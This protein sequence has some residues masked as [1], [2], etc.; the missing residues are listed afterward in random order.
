MFNLYEMIAN[1]QNGAA[2]NAMAQQFGLTPQQ[3]QAAIEALLP[4]FTLGL[5]QATQTPQG[6]A[7]LFATMAQPQA[8]AAFE[9]P[10]FAAQMQQFGTDALAAMFGSKDV[11]RAVADQAAPFA[12]VGPEILKKMLPA[13]AALIMSGL[14]R[15]AAQTQ[16]GW[17]DMLDQVFKQGQAPTGQ[18][19]RPGGGDPMS[20]LLGSILGGMLGAG[21]AGGAAPRPAPERGSSPGLDQLSDLTRQFDAAGEEGRALMGQM[22]ET[23]RQVQQAQ[24]DGLQQIFDAFFGDA[25][26][27]RS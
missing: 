2:M 23:G 27:R 17:A 11:S 12:G 9:Q 21:G 14:F 3:T 5:K 8:R 25:A 24:I 13:V 4:A 18:A 22:F 19:P 20:D 1:A 15:S 10:P 16:S 26:R 7:A 6:L